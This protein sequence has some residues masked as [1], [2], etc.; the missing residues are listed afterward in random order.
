[1]KTRFTAEAKRRIKT[2][3]NWWR[4]HRPAAPALFLDE[5]RVALAQIRTMPNSGTP[6]RSSFGRHV[7]RVLLPQ[8]QQFLYYSVD[9]ARTEILVHIVWGAARRKQ[10]KL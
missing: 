7:R 4:D 9:P 3:R 8:T 2:V 5:L 1:V 10:P 6:Y